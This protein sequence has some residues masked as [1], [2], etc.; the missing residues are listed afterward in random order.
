MPSKKHVILFFAANPIDSERI[1]FDAE[2]KVVR[3]ELERSRYRDC[4]E[5]VERY[6]AEPDDLLRELRRYRPTIIH[7][8]GHGTGHAPCDSGAGD[9]ARRDLV[10]APDP[11]ARAGSQ[12]LFFQGPDGRARL[13][14]TTALSGAFEAT[15]Q[16]VKVVVLNACYA[17]EYADALL[18]RV[19]CVVGMAGAIGDAAAVKFAVGFYGGV[20]HGESL[21]AAYDQGRSA[22]DLAALPWE[23]HPRL[24]SREGVD[25]A[26]LVLA[27]DCAI[28]PGVS[29]GAGDSVASPA[30]GAAQVA[31]RLRAVETAVGRITRFEG[32]AGWAAIGVMLAGTALLAWRVR[33]ALDATLDVRTQRLAIRTRS[34]MQP[35]QGNPDVRELVARASRLT[36]GPIGASADDRYR[37]MSLSGA[38]LSI[39]LGGPTNVDPRCRLVFTARTG[40][41]DIERANQGDGCL[42]DVTVVAGPPGLE[43]RIDDDPVRTIGAHHSVVLRTKPGSVVT[44]LPRAKQIVFFGQADHAGFMAEGVEGSA[45]PG[46]PVHLP[47][48]WGGNE[49]FTVEGAVELEQ[50][51]LQED[52]LRLVGSLR[53]WS[54]LL[55]QDEDWRARA[56]WPPARYCWL[57]GVVLAGLGVV[58]FRVRRSRAQTGERP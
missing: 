31:R 34:K 8:S 7:F 44:L 2:A 50:L 33:L 58:M 27:T 38:F 9:G 15:G 23:D 40:S 26:R 17:D 19:D 18:S 36:E 4:F 42:H 16:S 28:V 43:L 20:G 54:G 12:G 24:R 37:R 35:V 1:A 6:A 47:G 56:P 14:S 55:G 57:V 32:A 45:A 29:P 51:W 10:G 46:E 48:A 22:I 11:G 5:L 53:H 13:V 39:E 25:P 41:V 49:T 3:A 21:K 30:H 52:R